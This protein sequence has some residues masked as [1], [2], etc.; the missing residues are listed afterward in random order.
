MTYG[1]IICQGIPKQGLLLLPPQ[2]CI[3]GLIKTPCVGSV[4]CPH[5]FP[6][7]LLLFLL[8]REF[9]SIRSGD[10]KAV[11]YN[12]AVDSYGD[13]WSQTG[14]VNR[15]PESHCSPVVCLSS[16]Y[17]LFL[18]SMACKLWVIFYYIF[19]YFGSDMS[20]ACQ[21]AKRQGWP[22]TWSFNFFSPQQDLPCVLFQCSLQLSHHGGQD[23]LLITCCCGFPLYVTPVANV[24]PLQKPRFLLFRL[25][26]LRQSKLGKL[27]IVRSVYSRHIMWVF[28]VQTC[29]VSGTKFLEPCLYFCKQFQSGNSSSRIQISTHPVVSL[30][31][32]SEW[33]SVLLGSELFQHPSSSGTT[34]P[35]YCFFIERCQHLCLSDALTGALM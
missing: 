24:L 29:F 26:S 9:I 5:S 17:C 33:G 23:S 18:L 30:N 27:S 6:P 13:P 20:I 10:L 12:R 8:R 2:Q 4:K 32:S 31:P 16:V 19:L 34:D 1:A 14:S 3:P 28:L 7:A 25:Y 15:G 22:L 21:A 35:K 11:L